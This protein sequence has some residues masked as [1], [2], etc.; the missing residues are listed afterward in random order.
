[1]EDPWGSPWAADDSPPKIDLP[2]APPPVL[3]NSADSHGFRA[4]LWEGDDSWGEWND[5]FAV[6]ANSPGWGRSPGLRPAPAAASRDVSPG[7]W[8]KRKSEE[9][10]V[11]SAISL[12]KDTEGVVLE[13]KLPSAIA[14]DAQDVWKSEFP[15]VADEVPA[16][17]AVVE[18]PTRS[19]SPDILPPG[20]ALRLD[21]RPEPVRQGSKVQELVE[22]YDGIAKRSVSP[23]NPEL[24]PPPPL[25]KTRTPEDFSEEDSP[26]S[27][28]P[29]PVSI[30]QTEPAE[31]LDSEPFQNGAV[32]HDAPDEKAIPQEDIR[33][34][35]H[36]PR[37]K[38]PAIKIPIDLSKL[39]DIFP[40]TPAPNP[41]PEPLPD[42]II[43]D[44]F[45]SISERKT[46]YR[47]SRFGS[48]RKH[49]MGNDDNYV[50]I[51]WKHSTALE[52]T[53]KIVRRWMEEDSIA[54]RVVLGGRQK[55]A[56]GGSMFNWDSS[57]PEV[58]I[59]ALLGKKGHS[60]EP[61]VESRK[62]GTSPTTA[63][64]PGAPET[65]SA[66]SPAVAAFGWSSPAA[67]PTSTSFS[68]APEPQPTAAVTSSKSRPQSLIIP[69]GSAPDNAAAQSK[70]RPRSRITPPSSA[71][72]RPS[73]DQAL[74]MSV[75]SPLVAPPLASTN[76]DKDNDD[77]WGEMVSSPSVPSSGPFQSSTLAAEMKG[78][79]QPFST[80]WS[81][82]EP[83]ITQQPKA[84][85][86]DKPEP[87]SD[88]WGFGNV[89]LLAGGQMQAPRSPT[90]STA[91]DLHSAKDASSQP[92]TKSPTSIPP[93]LQLPTANASLSPS[94]PSLEDQKDDEAVALVLD[95]L[96]DLSYMLR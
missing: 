59:G 56:I 61:S 58:E 65:L 11:D 27:E 54:G 9:K 64:F 29:S 45:A 89:E 68:T 24:V 37:P 79:E 75:S 19:E 67:S 96:P 1:M 38:A 6:G 7:P 81:T 95:H 41:D 14:F 48:M 22:M 30:V 50:R 16:S 71:A 2:A 51:D 33:T 12:R 32:P 80:P 8:D 83:T 44:T 18:T 72:E 73:I 60:K 15:A 40:S 74:A 87:V 70:Q 47:I 42:T 25:G 21:E 20:P 57:A 39:D 28:I 62:S 46:W 31:E 13:A 94:T 78:D 84:A 5:A 26:V 63:S 10:I 86:P 82:E 53:L 77:D 91:P 35:G 85:S 76:V 43:D 23:A 92:A 69:S 52:D 93:P 4:N 3:A 34:E 90:A 66:A 88:P 36:A 17:P 55:G 49:N